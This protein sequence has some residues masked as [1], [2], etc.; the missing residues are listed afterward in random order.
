MYL[1]ENYIVSTKSLV[2]GV[3]PM[4]RI[5]SKFVYIKDFNSIL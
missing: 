5:L 1:A 2:K 3:F 4:L